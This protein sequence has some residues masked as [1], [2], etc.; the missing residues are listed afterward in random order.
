MVLHVCLLLPRCAGS[1]DGTVTVWDLRTRQPVRMLQKAGKGAV[2]GVLVMDRPPFLAA[3]QGGRGEKG[4]HS[5]NQSRSNKGP[6]RP[7]PLAPFSKYQ[8]SA[9][10]GKPWEGLPVV[11]DGGNS[12][13]SAVLQPV[14]ALVPGCAAGCGICSR[15]SVPIS[16]AMLQGFYGSVGTI[17]GACCTS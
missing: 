10:T 12:Y 9:G 15:R 4:G 1:D 7:Q 13:R 5:G 17:M 2:S 6:E 11:I 8:G 16:A 14:K 3:G